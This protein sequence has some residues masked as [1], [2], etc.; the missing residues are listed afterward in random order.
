MWP[1][2][3]NSSSNGPLDAA[4]TPAFGN[5]PPVISPPAFGNA[6]TS[7]WGSGLIEPVLSS[8]LVGEPTRPPVVSSAWGLVATQ[9]NNSSCTPPIAASNSPP[10]LAAGSSWGS[11]VDSVPLSVAMQVAIP[12]VNSVGWMGYP[13]VA[14]GG[15]AVGYSN[16]HP[17]EFPA[18]QHSFQPASG[19]DTANGV[20][21]P[22]ID[23]YGAAAA[24][25]CDSYGFNGYSNNYSNPFFSQ[26]GYSS[27]STP[28]IGLSQDEA[29]RK[30]VYIH[31]H[32]GSSINNLMQ[33]FHR[34]SI[35]DV[36]WL[37]TPT[38]IF[39]SECMGAGSVHNLNIQTANLEHYWYGFRN[40]R[41]ELLNE[42][43]FTCNV[44]ELTTKIKAATGN[45]ALMLWIDTA[46]GD[47]QVQTCPNPAPKSS[48]SKKVV[49]PSPVHCINTTNIQHRWKD[50]PDFIY[51]PVPDVIM[52]ISKMVTICTNAKTYDRMQMVVVG[53]ELHFNGVSAMNKPGSIY[54]QP[55]N[56]YSKNRPVYNCTWSSLTFRNLV[57]IG[58]IAKNESEI[59]IYFDVRLRPGSLIPVNT[60]LPPRFD[61]VV[62]D[63]SGRYT[64][65][66][67]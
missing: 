24:A 31:F 29:M 25:G 42:G 61:F 39:I 21:P 32:D 6:Q 43:S 2:Y 57:K 36:T 34:E 48:R 60:Q 41:G 3:N 10:Q 63:F 1:A 19:Y 12:P 46:H 49:E 64:C 27:S 14:G 65:F 13:Q 37:C 30:I 45:V 56:P 17:Y 38:N 58:A 47:V 5:A 16:S 66:L 28:L 9:N 33:V 15:A 52:S 7:A 23:N 35:A 20:N 59:H 44:K 62:G 50:M 51:Q 40:A 54:R 8:N 26:G 55:L 67:K 11:G 53:N 22:N 18:P 4:H